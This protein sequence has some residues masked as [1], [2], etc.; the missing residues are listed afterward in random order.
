RQERGVPFR[1]LRGPA[2]GPVVADGALEREPIAGPLLLRVI[3]IATHVDVVLVV[4][5]P[6]GALVGHAI[7]NPV[8]EPVGRPVRLTQVAEPV[9]HVTG[10]EAVGARHI[11]EG[12][13]PHDDVVQVAPADE[14]V[15][16]LRAVDEAGDAAVHRAPRRALFGHPDQ[17]AGLARL[18]GLEA[19]PAGVVLAG[20]EL[21]ETPL[22]HGRRPRPLLDD[23]RLLPLR[24]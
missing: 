20:P 19:A 7:V 17:V 12:A 4:V 16:A 23:D 3:A 8:V 18:P 1:L 2:P 6:H 5:D 14:E 9:R 22:A 15:V 21:A 24:G 10:L 11:G 13:A